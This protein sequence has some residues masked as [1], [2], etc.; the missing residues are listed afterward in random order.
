MTRPGWRPFGMFRS[1]GSVSVRNP[2][3]FTTP[4]H[5]AMPTEAPNERDATRRL[6]RVIVVGGGISGLA[7]AERLARS[8][9]PV[10]VTLL[11][12]ANRLGGCIGTEHIDGFVIERGPDVFLSSKPAALALCERVGVADRVIR[13]SAAVRGPHIMRDGRLHRLPAG[14][15]G[16]VPTRLAPFWRTPLLSPL[17][18]LRV[19]LEWGVPARHGD[20]E[21]SVRAFATR[22]LGREMYERVI[23]PLMS[24]IYAGDGDRFSIDA[25]FPRLREMERGHGGLL[26]AV[27]GRR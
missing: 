18:K 5:A 6:R 15:V 9:P 17:A 11:E 20:E 21:E 24:G 3:G 16:L 27:R 10:H 4:H 26:R 22:R 7:A 8:E 19:A 12:S 13:T 2:L 14:M 25:T 23:E 1:T